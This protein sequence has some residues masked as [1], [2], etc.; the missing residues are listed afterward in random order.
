MLSR[1]LIVDQSLKCVDI[2]NNGIQ[3]MN[4]LY[5]LQLHTPIQGIHQTQ[6]VISPTQCRKNA[7]G[8]PTYLSYN[9]FLPAVD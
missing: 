2:I 1:I 6:C 8:K 9:L 7:N 3:F 5:D 4:L